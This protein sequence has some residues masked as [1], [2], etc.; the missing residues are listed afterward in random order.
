M[1][2][3]DGI[4][5]SLNDE[6]V[7]L[8][9]SKQCFLC[10]KLWKNTLDL[11]ARLPYDLANDPGT[12]AD[13][14]RLGALCPF[15]LWQLASMAS[16]TGLSLTL[17]DI[18]D[19]MSFG[20]GAL[21]GGGPEAGDRLDLLSDPGRRCRVCSQIDRWEK[22]DLSDV[23][24]LLGSRE[25]RAAYEKSGGFCFRH[26][27]LVIEGLPRED[28][29]FIV[30]R[31]RENFSALAR[32]LRSYARKREELRRD[33]LQADERSAFSRALIQFGGIKYLRYL[34]R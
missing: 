23:R 14:A 28:A 1:I 17:A 9:A 33:L 31:S 16:A 10:G 18:A 29:E 30:T 3:P 5:A 13:Y 20:L 19:N 24:L 26:T 12:R 4:D 7:K 25:G 34:H 11:F 15:H 27:A 8:A 21:M 2:H 22:D 6:G 32:D